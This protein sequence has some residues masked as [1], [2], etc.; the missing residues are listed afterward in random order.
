VSEMPDKRNFVHENERKKANMPE[1]IKMP[2]I[3]V[4]CLS[5]SV[6]VLQRAARFCLSESG[7]KTET[8]EL[9]NTGMARASRCDVRHVMSHSSLETGLS[10]SLVNAD[11]AC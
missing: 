1:G 11:D 8:K 9:K 5:F 10:E 4:P 6:A 2:L 3:H 7:L